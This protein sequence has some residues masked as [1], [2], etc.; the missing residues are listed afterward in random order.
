MFG[1]RVYNM[2]L[3]FYSSNYNVGIVCVSHLYIFKY[4]NIASQKYT[5]FNPSEISTKVRLCARVYY[6]FDNSVVRLQQFLKT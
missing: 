6:Y 3:R 1:G 4:S 5:K 2:Y